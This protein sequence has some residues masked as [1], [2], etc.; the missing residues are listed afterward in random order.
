MKI[1]EHGNG[2][3]ELRRDVRWILYEQRVLPTPEEK[4]EK[5]R[6]E[7]LMRSRNDPPLTEIWWSCH[8]PH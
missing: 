5:S 4:R 8:A 7:Q 2:V 3:H 6:Q 1:L